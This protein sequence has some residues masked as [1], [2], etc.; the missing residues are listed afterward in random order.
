MALWLPFY[1]KRHGQLESKLKAKVLAASAA[2]IESVAGALPD[3]FGQ[4][5]SLRHA[6]RHTVAQSDPHW[7]RAVGGEWPRVLSKRTAW[8]T[9]VKAW[10]GNF[11]GALAPPMCTPNGPRRAR[12]PM[13]ARRQWR[14]VLLRS[15]RPCPCPS[16]ASTPIMAA[17]CSTGTWGITF[18]NAVS[19]SASPFRAPTQR[20]TTREWNKRTGLMCGSWWARAPLEAE[21]VAE[22]LDALYRKEWSLFGNL[23]CPA[24]ESIGLEGKNR[25]KVARDFAPI[26]PPSLHQ[27]GLES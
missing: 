11:A 14:S 12:C 8:R 25:A 10:R 3:Q 16:R 13:G 7:H 6:S 9:A 24:H 22:L 18:A 4:P 5:G 27:S 26:S 1:E 2:T 17:S 23:F 19:P 21:P 20:T 15:K